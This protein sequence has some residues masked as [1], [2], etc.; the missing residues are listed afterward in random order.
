MG[1]EGPYIRQD[2]VFEIVQR[3]GFIAIADTLCGPYKM[4]SPPGSSAG[5]R[6]AEAVLLR[7]REAPASAEALQNWSRKFQAF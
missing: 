7:P 2:Y 1:V 4:Q 3:H 6:P 5:A